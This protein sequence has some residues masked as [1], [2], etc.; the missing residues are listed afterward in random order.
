[1][2]RT[3]EAAAATRDA[4]LRAALEV[5]ADRGYAAA[6]LADVAERAK[7]TRGAVYHHFADKAD[8]F[9][10]TVGEYWAIVEAPLWSALEGDD[11]ALV[12]VRRFVASY[13][14]AAERDDRLRR[15][16]EIMTVRA[17]A[18][19]ELEAGMSEKQDALELW[20]ERLSTVLELE[21]DALRD[22][23]KPRDAAMLA[24]TQ[25]TGVT[26]TWLLAP[27]VCR[28]ADV[29]DAVAD[30]WQRSVAR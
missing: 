9:L 4:V 3:K 25:V 16:L 21:P 28:P 13:L 30:A 12:R 29:A 22:G 15:L 20:V 6:K 24:V 14:E 23:L 19:P 17:E 10:S 1:M 5:F 11:P 8:L 7:V 2:K 18:L 26:T 27:A